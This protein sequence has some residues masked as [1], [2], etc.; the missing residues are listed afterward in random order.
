MAEGTWVAGSILAKLKLDTT[1]FEKGAGAA[2]KGT[3]TM[4]KEA[5]KA[6]SAFSGLWKQMAVG[7]GATA[8]VSKG[9][10]F[11]KSQI[12]DTIKVG[13]E[14]EKQWANA[15][16]QINRSGGA[17]DSRKREL[18]SLPPTL[19]SATD[20]AHGMYEVISAGIPAGKAIKFL[21]E[22]AK[23][24][25]AG[26]TDS[27]T[28]IDALT[29][30]INAY[31]LSA[32]DATRISDMMF[33]SVKR[34]KQTYEEMAGALG[35]VVPIAS[36]VGMGFDQVAAAMATLTRQGIDANTA[37]VQ[38]RQILVSVLNPSKEAEKM[39]AALGLE[40]NAQGQTELAFQKQMKTLD[41]WLDTA[42]NTFEK[43]KISF[44]EGFSGPIKE[45]ITTSKELETRIR[46]LQERFED[47][48]KKVGGVFKF[49]PLL[50]DPD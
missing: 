9:I 16:T 5:T 30:V 24:A 20:L 43:L 41:F 27:F 12:S 39:A 14:F 35:T 10:G 49:E 37:T 44:Y 32:E 13:R 22:S 47:F 34:G 6:H 15:T 28:A 1:T 25:K 7:I 4:A 33:E 36:Q 8:L 48:G 23:A 2:A 31:G 45:G 3:G 18:L 40:V 21:G 26:F 50:E 19:G 29:T 38:L 42:K 46:I 11:I 17:M